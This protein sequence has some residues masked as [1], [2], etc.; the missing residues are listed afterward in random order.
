MIDEITEG[1]D[2]Y[3]AMIDGQ[4]RLVRRVAEEM[5]TGVFIVEDYLCPGMLHRVHM[6][7]LRRGAKPVTV[8]YIDKPAQDIIDG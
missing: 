2:E 3:W 7:N 5:G 6:D 4:W 1:W 8:T